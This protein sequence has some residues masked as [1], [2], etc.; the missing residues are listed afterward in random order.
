[1]CFFDFSLFF[2][3]A[4]DGIRDRNVTGVQTCALPIWRPGA[5]GWDRRRVLERAVGAVQLFLLR[6]ITSVVTVAMAA[7]VPPTMASAAGLRS[8]ER[9]V[10][11]SGGGCGCGMSE[12]PYVY[13]VAADWMA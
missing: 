4:V 13:D 5:S 8:E 9:R 12:I 10:G 1:T 6:T 3:L 7:A 2:F 11:K